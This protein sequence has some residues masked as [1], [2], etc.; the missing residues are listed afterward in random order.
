MPPRHKNEVIP[1]SYP[2][3]A[4]RSAA[5]PITFGFSASANPQIRQDALPLQRLSAATGAVL[6][7][8][9]GITDLVV[10]V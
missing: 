6:I 4:R 1:Q 9:C 3:N 10:A 5:R 8:K 2:A 7:R